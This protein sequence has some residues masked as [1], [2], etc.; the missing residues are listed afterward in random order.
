M[1]RVLSTALLLTLLSGCI[2]EKSSEQVL[3]D[4]CLEELA[5]ELDSW[6]KYAGWNL[7]TA[8]AELLELE[9][10]PDEKILSSQMMRFKI[11]VSNF[12]VK[13]GFNADVRSTA[14]C[15]G[16]VLRFSSGKYEKP[17]RFFMDFTLNGEKFG[18]N[19]FL[20]QSRNS[21]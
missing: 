1:R 3:L 7:R 15:A 4:A 20:E 12:T 11:L 10:I 16:E 2:A 17:S 5:V 6:A 21:Q 18:L 14:T 8:E 9:E 19:A 13:N